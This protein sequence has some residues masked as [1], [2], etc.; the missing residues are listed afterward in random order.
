M[1][2]SRFRRLGAQPIYPITMLA[3]ALRKR[4]CDREVSSSTVKEPPPMRDEARLKQIAE[5]QL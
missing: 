4:L 2:A 1:E 5:V 3:Q